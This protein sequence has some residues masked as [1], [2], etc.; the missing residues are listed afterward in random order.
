MTDLASPVHEPRRPVWIDAV[1]IT[2]FGTEG[3]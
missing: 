1:F 3:A 2:D